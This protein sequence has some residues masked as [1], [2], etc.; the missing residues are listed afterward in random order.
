MNELTNECF[1]C[2][3]EPKYVIGRSSDGL[4]APYCRDCLEIF[5]SMGGE[6]NKQE[7]SVHFKDED[8]M[9]AASARAGVTQCGGVYKLRE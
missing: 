7:Y 3:A 4:Q 2:G 8:E 1:M 5:F 6:D 9:K